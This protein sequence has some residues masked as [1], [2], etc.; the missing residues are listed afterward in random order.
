MLKMLRLGLCCLFHDV[1][2]I[3]FRTT[4]VKYLTKLET[5]KTGSRLPYVADIVLHN[6]KMLRKAIE[7]CN[8]N[9]IGCF[10]INSQIWPVY[11]HK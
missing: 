6:A 11:T 1:P 8:N 3:K 10:R 9:G 7:Y 5:E 4:T 2:E